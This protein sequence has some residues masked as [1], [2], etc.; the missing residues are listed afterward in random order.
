M[1]TFEKSR[2]RG[3]LRKAAKD[4]EAED[5]Y[6]RGAGNYAMLEEKDA[7]FAALEKE[8]AQRVVAHQY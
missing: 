2:Y 8:F 6:Y 5:D 3:Y 4:S 7:A 1:Q